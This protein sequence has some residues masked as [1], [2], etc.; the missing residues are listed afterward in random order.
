MA[1]IRVERKAGTKAWLWILL[2]LVALALALYLLYQGGYIGGVAL[3][4]EPTTVQQARLA[5]LA[6]AVASRI[7]EVFHG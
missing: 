5:P 6:L 3:G 4:H 1:D 2:A 7:Q